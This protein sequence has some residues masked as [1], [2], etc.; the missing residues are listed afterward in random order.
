MESRKQ[1]QTW[2]GLIW[3]D[4]ISLSLSLFCFFKK[5]RSR[6]ATFKSRHWMVPSFQNKWSLK[7]A[8]CETDRNTAHST[9]TSGILQLAISYQFSPISDPMQILITLTILNGQSPQHSTKKLS[10]CK[11]HIAPRVLTAQHSGLWGLLSA[12][13]F[14]VSGSVLL[15][16][17]GPFQRSQ[18]T[19]TDVCSSGTELGGTE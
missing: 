8:S 11:L 2:F 16:A 15:S 3:F 5:C 1:P 17:C 18:D 14:H 4:V 10:I 13:L 7:H 12:T 19:G 6:T 9:L